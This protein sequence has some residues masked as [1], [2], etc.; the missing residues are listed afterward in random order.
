MRL[1][2]L[3]LPFSRTTNY[4]RRRLSKIET[5]VCSGDISNRYESS[6]ISP[7]NLSKDDEE[8]K[9]RTYD[10]IRIRNSTRYRNRDDKR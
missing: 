3:G 7:K 1:G 10:L 5:G 2:C 8:R 9:L 6:Y 4:R